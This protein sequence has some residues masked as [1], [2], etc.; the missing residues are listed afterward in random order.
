VTELEGHV[1][2]V[3]ER[4]DAAM[5]QGKKTMKL[6]PFALMNP[7]LKLL[8]FVMYALNLDLRFLGLPRDPFGG[9][10]ITN[11]GS[12]GLDVAY[13]PLTPYTRTPIYVA[14]GAV[15]DTPVV[16]NGQVVAGKVMTVNATF[17]HRFID[18]YHASVLSK[19][20]R[21]FLEDPFAHF[22]RLEGLP[23]GEAPPAAVA[24]AG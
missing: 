23:A 24:S 14:P 21:A 2:R 3:R 19:T 11:I 20:L 13:V 15:K 17:D 16:E 7:F 8:S 6:I 12:L 1:T 5:E 9:C 10:T 22:D 4:K 18:G